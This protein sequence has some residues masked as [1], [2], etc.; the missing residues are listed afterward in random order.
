MMKMK[1]PTI[2]NSEKYIRYL[3]VT[4]LYHFRTQNPFLGAVGRTRGIPLHTP[5]KW[6]PK[7]KL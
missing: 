7:D 2:K 4:Q 5:F 1:T 3:N 6:V